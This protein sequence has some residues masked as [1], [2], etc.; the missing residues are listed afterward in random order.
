[1]I[2]NLSIVIPTV[3]YSEYLDIAIESCLSLNFEKEIVISVNNL[4][5][6][7]YKKSC[8]FNDSR[9]E[10]RCIGKKIVP[11]Y[12][13]LNYAVSYASK[14]WVFILSDDDFL[15]NNFLKGINLEDLDET[16]LYS[17]TVNSVNKNG[18]VIQ[19]A[20]PLKKNEYID[21]EIINLFFSNMIH[22]HLSLFVFNKKN[23]NKCGKFVF[24]GYPNSY[25]LDTVL[26]GKFM[27][28]SSKMIV[29]RE[30]VVSRR[31]FSE[32]ASAKFYFDNVNEYFYTIVE[33]LFSDEKFKNLAITKYKTK[34]IF[35][36]KMI[37]D[38]FFIEW[39][40][41]NKIIYNDSWWNKI[42]FF[43]KY[44]FFW[45]AGFFFKLTSFFYILLFPLK[46]YLSKSVLNNMKKYLGKII[47]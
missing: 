27:A 40:K 8:Y 34:H 25:Y 9:L 11:M 43:Y 7:K 16:F 35:H 3:N 22:N 13:S 17:T 18:D 37:R 14:D 44:L 4:N 21:G 15:H 5:Y 19:G 28:N 33:T 47:V 39:S 24:T 12:E 1:M 29:S 26:H 2:K 20:S 31:M 38:R 45:N 23:F 32:Q 36:R 42:I 30:V 41:L 46:K 6:D 10:W